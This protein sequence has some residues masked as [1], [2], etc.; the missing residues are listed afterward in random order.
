MNVLGLIPARGGSKGIKG[1]N[2]KSLGG[3]PLIEYTFDAALES[4]RLSRIILSTD[5]AEIAEIGKRRGIGVPFIRPSDISSDESPARSYVQHCLDFLRDNEN[6]KP[7]VIVILQ[8]TT[9]F[10]NASDIDLCVN[11]LLQ[12]E[13]D[14]VISVAEQPSKYHPNWYLV[15]SPD[16]LLRPYSLRSWEQVVPRRQDLLPIYIRNG[17]VYV[18]WHKTFLKTKNIYGTKVIPYIMPPERSINI[19]DMGDWQ[20]AEFAISTNFLENK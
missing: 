19:D 13:C 11:L 5:S 10:R 20:R 12:C 15:V 14:S 7:D 4:K 1:K 2:I 3:K 9:P 16:G 17:A 8:P 6:Y 18:F